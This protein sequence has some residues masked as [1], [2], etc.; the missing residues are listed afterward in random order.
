MT[1]WFSAMLWPKPTLQPEKGE[2]FQISRVGGEGGGKGVYN[3]R[4]YILTHMDKKKKKSKILSI[5]KLHTLYNK[6]FQTS[7]TEEAD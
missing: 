3:A 5:C 6:A 1:V 2:E 4:A 7:D